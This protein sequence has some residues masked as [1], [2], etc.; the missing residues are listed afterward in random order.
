MSETQNIH[1]FAH[2]IAAEGQADTV[3][4]IVTALAN[5]AREEPGNLHYM[6]HEAGPGDFYFFEVY[7]NQAAVDAHMGSAHFKAAAAKFVP[8]LVK[9]PHI[10]V[11]K[12]IAGS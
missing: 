9:P 6:V 3:R 10:V 1:V 12:L 7:Q 8:L 11:T 4:D 2:G 5:Q